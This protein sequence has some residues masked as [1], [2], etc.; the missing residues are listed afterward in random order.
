VSEPYFPPPGRGPTPYREPNGAKGEEAPPAKVVVRRAEPPKEE[1]APARA[2]PK[3]SR[4]EVSALLATSG[5]T[6]SWGARCGKRAAVIVIPVGLIRWGLVLVFG[7][8]APIAATV[9]SGLCAIAALAW[10]AAPLWRQN[11]EGWS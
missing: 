8:S 6:P 1:E 10:I 5:A 9:L 3:L 4:E 11:R 7:E 2:A